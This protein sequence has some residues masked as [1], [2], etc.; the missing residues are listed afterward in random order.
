MN[1]YYRFSWTKSVFLP[2]FC[3]TLGAI[4][5]LSIAFGSPNIKNKLLGGESTSELENTA[6]TIPVR[7]FR[8][9]FSF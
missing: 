6:L 2:F 5:V 9:S 7:K 8:A 1:N 3:G 4:L